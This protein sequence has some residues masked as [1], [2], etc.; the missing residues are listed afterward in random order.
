MAHP[1]SFITM[2]CSCRCIMLQGI[3]NRTAGTAEV[4]AHVLTRAAWWLQGNLAFTGFLSDPGNHGLGTSYI[5]VTDITG[6]K[7]GRP[8]VVHAS[9]LHC[10]R[11]PGFVWL[12]LQ[13]NA[14]WTDPFA[15]MDPGFLSCT[16][17]RHI[18]CAPVY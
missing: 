12:A 18:S 5:T 13:Y 14:F 7:G 9:P 16:L 10:C 17:K 6:G 1:V 11:L 15:H 2:P 3:G 8:K 4:G